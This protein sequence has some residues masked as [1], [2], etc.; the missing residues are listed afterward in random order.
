VTATV[1]AFSPLDFFFGADE[2]GDDFFDAG[3]EDVAGATGATGAT[4]DAD[5]VRLTVMLRNFSPFHS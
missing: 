5:F 1:T 2:T 3:L 4:G